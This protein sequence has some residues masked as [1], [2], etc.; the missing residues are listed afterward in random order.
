MG[1]AAEVRLRPATAADSERLF[2]WRNLPDVARWMYSD[3][4]ITA[5]EHARWIATALP[6]PTRRYWIIE[7]DGT[8]VGLAG[9]VDISA[10]NRKATL[11]HYLADPI[12][13]GRG[14]GAFV[15][16][17]LLDQAFGA[18]KLN[19]LSCEVLYENERAWRLH[20]GFGFTRE[21]YYRAHI[22]K[23]G[24]PHDAVGLAILADEWGAIRPA[25]V[26]R[27]QG[28]GFAIAG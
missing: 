12:T 17:W 4:V 9:L 25:S 24:A 5:D 1:D 28:K 21:A 3:H 16:V 2:H 19:K 27:L 15:E 13:R 18:L 8:P 22:W 26:A 11:I 14:L 10:Q 23:A 6:D 7:M 20:E